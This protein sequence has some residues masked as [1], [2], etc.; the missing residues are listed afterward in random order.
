MSN[1][2]SMS[3]T[4]QNK[5]NTHTRIATEAIG[6]APS[7]VTNEDLRKLRAQAERKRKQKGLKK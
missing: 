4:K 5:D 7:P 2:Y 6:F 1:G 3:D